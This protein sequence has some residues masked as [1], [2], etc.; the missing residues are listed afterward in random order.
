MFIPINI[1]IVLLMFIMILLACF[2]ITIRQVRTLDR[3][4][5]ESQRGI[6]KQ[7]PKEQTK[8]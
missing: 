6:S 5:T 4:L 7:T 1:V 3:E 8:T 2:V